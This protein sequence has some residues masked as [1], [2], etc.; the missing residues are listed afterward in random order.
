M[1]YKTIC[2]ALALIVLSSCAFNGGNNRNYNDNKII[3]E[4]DSYSA[5]LF[6]KNISSDGKGYHLKIEKFD[7]NRE[8]AHANIQYD[9]EINVSLLLFINSGKVKL[10][11]IKPNNEVVI[12]KEILKSNSEETLENV[13]INCVKGVNKI[14]LVAENAK[15]VDLKFLDLTQTFE[16]TDDEMFDKDFPFSHKG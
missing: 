11:H 8:M 3:A 14:K 10:V 15:E 13:T 5:T 6:N 9:C 2:P 7:G 4:K 16:Y 1:N 12:L